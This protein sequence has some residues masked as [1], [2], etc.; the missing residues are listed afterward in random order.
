MGR[1]K[2]SLASVH[3]QA[4]GKQSSSDGLFIAEKQQ[5]AT[6]TPKCKRVSF[7]I[8][9]YFLDEKGEFVKTSTTSGV[10][11]IVRGHKSVL[12]ISF[13]VIAKVICM[14]TWVL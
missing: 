12:S 10:L 11:E 8:W 14:R 4:K 9:A 5:I 2:L 7:C 3:A 13:S 1:E 6:G